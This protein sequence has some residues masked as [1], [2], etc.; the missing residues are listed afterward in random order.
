[1]PIEAD[2]VR[3]H[4][5]DERIRVDAF[6]QGLEFTERLVRALAGK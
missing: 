3:A 5:R 1:V 6:Y 4:G 2:D